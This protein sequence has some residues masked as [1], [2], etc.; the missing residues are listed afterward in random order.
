[1]P[2]F[3]R[4]YVHSIASLVL[5]A[6]VFSL[7]ICA[8]SVGCAGTN[9]GTSGITVFAAAS[10]NDAFQDI[11]DEF[12]LENPGIDVKLNFAG[13]Q[14]L[15][16]QLDLGARADVF[17]SADDQQMQL[18]QEAGLIAENVQY[19][20]ST[21]M[22]V[23]VSDRSGISSLRD[24]G[25]PGAKVVLAH[26]SVPA[27]HYSRQLLQHLSTEESGL[28]EGYAGRVLD[29]VVSEE[30]SVNYVEQKVVIGQADAGIV[31]LPGALR[32]TASSSVRSLP[33][34]PQADAVR[35]LY[36]IATLGDST[37][38]DLGDEFINFVLSQAGQGI[39]ASYGFDA[40]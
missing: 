16:S 37:S 32:A 15:R 27:G 40:P 13:S 3:P 26:G 14:R 23:I 31:Y 9:D 25:A 5:A 24:L 7:L 4:N 36:P 11:A 30:T 1:M 29:N 21:S 8:G 6:V 12:E 22:S 17:A 28:G 10:L 2:T 35:A 39:L 38:K 34:P 20:A 19:F 33:L 18:A